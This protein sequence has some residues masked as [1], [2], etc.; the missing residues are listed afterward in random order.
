MRS[1]VSYTENAAKLTNV[2]VTLKYRAQIGH[3]NTSKIIPRLIII[4]CT[5]TNKYNRLIDL[6]VTLL[7]KSLTYLGLINT[8]CQWETLQRILSLSSGLESEWRILCSLP[9]PVFT[10]ES[11]ISQTGLS[12]SRHYEQLLGSCCCWLSEPLQ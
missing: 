3:T 4:Y 10:Q 6:E 12:C 5:V 7:T 11:L 2:S 1:K 9:D 8:K